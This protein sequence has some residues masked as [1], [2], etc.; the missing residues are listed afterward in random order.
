MNVPGVVTAVDLQ[1]VCG[2]GENSGVSFSPGQQQKQSLRP[3]RSFAGFS[4]R[5]VNVRGREGR[6][7]CKRVFVRTVTT[8]FQLVY[9]TCVTFVVGMNKAQ[10]RLSPWSWFRTSYTQPPR[11]H[12]KHHHPQKNMLN[13]FF[14]LSDLA[15]NVRA[16]CGGE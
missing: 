6:K 14:G 11:S 16:T 3:A 15:F 1:L 13:I 7:A 8:S 10:C 2:R 4:R 12:A 9:R 5:S